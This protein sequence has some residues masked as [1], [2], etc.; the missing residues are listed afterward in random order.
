MYNI[1]SSAN[2]MRRFV[3]HGEVYLLFPNYP[4]IQLGGYWACVPLEECLSP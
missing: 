1:Y 3:R 2:S 4:V